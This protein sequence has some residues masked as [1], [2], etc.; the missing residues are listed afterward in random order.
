M[1]RRTFLGAAAAFTTL[2]GSRFQKLV[3]SLHTD[4]SEISREE[5]PDWIDDDAD[6][7]DAICAWAWSCANDARTALTGDEYDPETAKQ[8]L[9]TALNI[10]EAETD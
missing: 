3:T 7:D 6:R 5:F 2:P 9:P 10:L 8:E 4:S 1:D